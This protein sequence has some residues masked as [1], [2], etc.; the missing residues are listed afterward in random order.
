VT[1]LDASA[2][3]SADRPLALRLDGRQVRLTHPQRVLWPRVGFTKRQLVDYLLAIAPV[4]LPHVRGR[5]L[6]LRRFPEGVHGPGWFQ[7]ECRGCPSWM[8]TFDV[9]GQAGRTWHYCVVDDTAGLVWTANLGTLEL[10]PFLSTIDRP[11]EPTALV[12]DL[13]PGP[14]AGLLACGR[15][16]LVLRSRLADLGLTAFVKTSGSVGLHVEVP[17]APGHS[18]DRTKAFARS[19]AAC[20]SAERPDLVT[21]VIDRSRRGG[22]VY[23]DWI[24]NDQ[25]RST[26]APYSLRATPWP[27]VSTPLTWSEL[28]EAVATDRPESLVFGPG[29]VLGRV[30]RLGDLFAPLADRAGGATLPDLRGV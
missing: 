19:L 16:A 9:A 11:T 26:V 5:G 21:D 29:D 23:L 1:V 2:A 13:D 14:P 25:S 3:G 20:G 30:E 24:Q 28:E 27:L 8:R 15:L 17:L 22:L 4:L 6:T 12:L 7:A 10:H 18:F